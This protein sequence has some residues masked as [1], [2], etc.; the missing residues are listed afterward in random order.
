LRGQIIIS[1]NFEGQFVIFW[2]FIGVK[3]K[4]LE[5]LRTKM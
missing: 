5:N 2:K 4:I 3:L 1:E